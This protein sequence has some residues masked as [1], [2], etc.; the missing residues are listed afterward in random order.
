MYMNF[1]DYTNDNCMALFT[2]DQSSRFQATMQFGD[3]R[4]I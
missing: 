1:M 4:K 3:F 2:N